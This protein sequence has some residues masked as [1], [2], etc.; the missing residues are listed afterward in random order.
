MKMR[1]PIT[2]VNNVDYE[3]DDRSIFSTGHT[4]DE[5]EAIKQGEARGKK[6]YMRE[7]PKC[8]L[9]KTTDKYRDNYRRIFKHD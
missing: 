3:S 2:K 6:A 5:K 9:V 4:S 7:H 1:R 8:G